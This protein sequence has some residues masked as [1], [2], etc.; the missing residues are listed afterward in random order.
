M[1]SNY[2]IF[3]MRYILIIFWKKLKQENLFNLFVG[4]VFETVKKNMDNTSLIMGQP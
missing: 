3:I 2:K 1:L 4:N